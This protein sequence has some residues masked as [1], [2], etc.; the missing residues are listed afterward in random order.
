MSLA[1]V[2]F[3]SPVPIVGTSQRADYFAASDGWVVVETDRGVV[4]S[5]SAGQN[6]PAVPAFRVRGVGYSV[7]DVPAPGPIQAMAQ[8]AGTAAMF[9]D[10]RQPAA[11]GKR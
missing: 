11:K 4:L 5:R 8:V 3:V 2:Q 1:I 7:P 9:H 6:V 10:S